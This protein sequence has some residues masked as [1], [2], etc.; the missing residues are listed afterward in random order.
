MNEGIEDQMGR[1]IKRTESDGNAH[2]ST[3][4]H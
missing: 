1:M 4:E 2:I 3:I